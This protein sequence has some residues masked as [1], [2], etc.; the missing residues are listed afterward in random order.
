MVVT[1]AAAAGLGGCGGPERSA[2]AWCDAFWDKAIPLH[3]QYQQDA[4]LSGEDP[5]AVI[6]DLVSVSG[7]V[8]V[9]LDDMARVA[10]EEIRSDTEALRDSLE[11]S[12]DAA[13]DALS[14]PLGALGKA[15]S[16]ALGSIGSQ[17]RFDAYFAAHCGTP[18]EA[19]A[20]RG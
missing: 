14:D 17:R 5:T 8:Q 18:D 16:Q 19:R 7:D 13:G 12:Q 15:F 9:I 10:P 6:L 3:D 1:L 20:S 2:Q 4:D 11:K